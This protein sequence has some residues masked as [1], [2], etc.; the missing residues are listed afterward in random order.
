[1]RSRNVVIALWVVAQVTA[2][3]L[4]EG[5][6]P[7]NPAVVPHI[8][9]EQFVLPNGLTVVV[10]E[11]R[12]VP[13]VAV[14]VW[15]HVGSKN[16]KPGK[17]G[18]AHLFEHLMF[19]GSENY[20][21]DYF[22]PLEKVGATDL[23]GTTN[24][25]RTNYFQ[26]VPR[27]ALDLVLFLESDRMGHL[28]G[29]VDQ[30]RLDEQRGVVQNEKRQGENQ[31][32][33]LV[34]QLI[35]ESAYPV[36]H[37]YHWTTIG[38]MEDL[39][40][41]SLEDVHEWFGTYYGPNNAVVVVAGDIDPATARDRVEK[42]FGH[43]PPGLP[44]ARLDR[45]IA[46]M[47]G[48]RRG[49]LQDR[50][51]QSRV[52]KVWNVP[53]WG[54]AEADHLD[55]VSD[56]LAS[57]KTSRLYKRLVYDDQIATD[58]VAFISKREIGSQFQIMA[59]A[60]PG[61][62]L[63]AVER[64]V[65][66]ELQRLIAEGPAP[67]EM[68]RVKTQFRASFIRGAER[69][70]G[71]GGKSDVLATNMVYA[72]DPGFY[73]KTLQRVADATAEQ[74]QSV[75]RQW[76]SDGVYVLEVHPVEQ[77]QAAG[78]G[79]DRSSL[80]TVAELPA[81]RFP[82]LERTTL[83]NGLE[84]IL[85]RRDAVP[86]VDFHLLVDAGFAADQHG[87]PG[88]ASLAMNMLDEGTKTRNSLEISDALARIGARLRSG[89]NLDLSS[90]SLSTLVEHTDSG[91]VLLAD[92]IQNPSFPQPDFER[93]KAEQLARIQRE[94]ATPVQ[95]ALR[96][97]PQLLYGEGHAYS[98]PL[99]GSGTEESISGLSRDALVRF[100][101]DWF[102]PSNATL[103]AVGAITLAEL[104][105][106]LERLLGGWQSRSVPTKNVAE[107][108]RKTSPSVYLIDRPGSQQSII[109]AG[110][111]APPKNNKREVALEVLND[112]L[113]GSFSS[114]INM[115]LREEKG[116]SYGAFTFLWDA[117]GQRPF[118]AYAPVQT[119]KT[120]ESL[121]ELVGELR[122]I[123]GSRPATVDELAK[124]QANLTLSL[125]GRWETNAAVGES[126]AELVRF[127]L[128][129]DYYDGYAA[130]VRGV[131]V[132]E[133]ADV[134][135]QVVHPDALVWV[136]VGD[137]AKIEQSIR[138]LRLGEVGLLDTDGRPVSPGAS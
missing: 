25:D 72:G 112:L 44:I 87:V 57:G 125:P 49:V 67:E 94:K 96:V 103:V 136:I 51:P 11:D 127:R 1:M 79:V 95:I 132:E 64:A 59:T 55:L 99:T 118:I 102:T 30:G 71:F 32:Y 134:A 77:L 13:I 68:R 69:I 33:G 52:Y 39:E 80:P 31:P 23:N 97:F 66:E 43:I 88:T 24:P 92:V 37:P 2:P 29:A 61:G 116:W 109:F 122:D 91:L 81:P 114:R 19:N 75:A 62:G 12:K 124:A 123:I 35:A 54:S 128:P 85:A 50:V 89:S 63:A 86:A 7:A 104:T 20:D 76:L 90:V 74:L 8:A 138:D 17:T 26:N 106:K 93:L 111:V 34:R 22:G 78:D 84:V 28:L 131:V 9:F 53:E 46:K 10:H 65:D 115:N 58:V 27:P 135:R 40:A 101:Q 121:E 6:A 108:S 21:D 4:A 119:D 3:V 48:E 45:W 60:R 82:E 117:R 133:L 126:I 100:H 5:Q 107:V 70:G 15:Y 36:G 42:Y 129:H 113:G 56:V 137:Q 105:P 47:S 16:E 73:R 83:S 18:F 120:R 14:N 130:A 38:S 41:A 98:T 110:H